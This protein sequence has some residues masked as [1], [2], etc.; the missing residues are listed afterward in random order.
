MERAWRER[1][2]SD[3]CFLYVR[4]K[5]FFHD[6]E[7][8]E[9]T[10]PRRR[11]FLALARRSTSVARTETEF[12]NRAFPISL[13]KIWAH[14]RAHRSAANEV[15][16]TDPCITL[17]T[18]AELHSDRRR[19]TALLVDVTITRAQRVSAIRQSEFTS[20][21]YAH[22]PSNDN[23][24][25]RRRDFRGARVF[26]SAVSS[27]RTESR[28]DLLREEIS[29]AVSVCNASSRRASR[30]WQ[31]SPGM[32]RECQARSSAHNRAK[33][34]PRLRLA[35]TSNRQHTSK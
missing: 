16:A 8:L 2:L 7:K 30:R 18:A 19:S 25:S 24:R 35:P 34:A 3:W 12:I 32:R 5:I 23:L 14:S 26:P 4:V 15:D 9:R 27:R 29:I 10:F 33:V 11:Q 20:R 28:R 21:I 13:N 17:I 31:A 22:A 6:K 1:L